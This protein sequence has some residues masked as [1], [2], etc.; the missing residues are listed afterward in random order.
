MNIK[1]GIAG[2]LACALALLMPL[3]NSLADDPQDDEVG[4]RCISL[5]RMDRIEVVD[6]QNLLVYMRG[7]DIYRNRLRNRCPGLRKNRPLM[8]STTTSQL[9][10]LD[11]ITVLYDRGAGFTPGASCGLGRFI[12]VSEE[13]AEALTT[14]RPAPETKPVPGAQPEEVEQPE[15]Q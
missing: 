11:R 10:D 7:G 5:H 14:E 3:D 6:P 2:T 9:C 12:P 1:S 15:E 13:D 4:E 8:Y